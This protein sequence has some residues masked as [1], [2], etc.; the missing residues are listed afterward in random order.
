V[1]VTIILLLAGSWVSTPPGPSVVSAQGGGEDA[2]SLPGGWMAIA[3]GDYVLALA[4]EGEFVWAGT[5]AGGAIRWDPATGAYTQYL[6]PQHGIAGNIVYDIAI[7]AAGNRWFATNRGLSRLAPDGSWSTFTTA[8][9]GG[10]LPSDHVTAVAVGP[11]GEVWV[12]TR[13]LMRLTTSFDGHEYYAGGVARL[14]PNGTWNTWTV[15]QGVSS[16]NIT[17]IAIEPGTGKVWVT[18]EPYRYWIPPTDPTNPQDMGSWGY[19]GGGVSLWTGDRWTIYQRTT[20]Q[21]FPSHDTVRAVAIDGQGRRWFATWG[22][23]LNVLEG[24]S[25]WTKFTASPGGLAGNY[26]TSLA[27][28]S[29][30][31]VWCGVAGSVA[32]QGRGVSVLNHNGTISDPTDDVWTQYTRETT[33]N[34]LAGDEVQAILIGADGAVWFGTGGLKGNGSGLSRLTT[35]GTWSTF[36]TA[37]NGLLSNQITAI[38]FGPDGSVW[39]GTGDL[40]DWGGR[41]RGVNVLRADGSWTSYNAAYRSRG[42][43]VTTVTAAAA[44]GST[45]IPVGFTSRTQA[46]AALP[47]GLVMFGDDPTIYTYITFYSSSRT[48]KIQPGLVQ[49]V[50]AGTPVYAVNLGLAS[51]NV[52]DIAFDASG[53]PWVGSRWETWDS[54]TQVWLDGGVSTFDGA[55]T[56]YTESSGLISN[57]VSAVAIE[58]PNCGGKIWVGTGRLYDYSGFGISRFDPAQ[59]TWVRFTS[60]LSSLNITDAVVDPA[61]CNVWFAT[62]PY[63]SNGNWTGGGVSLFDRASSSWIKLNQTSGLVAYGDDVRSIAV[64]PEGVVWAG[65]YQYTGRQLSLDWP[66]VSAAVNRRL[67]GSWTS[68]T[69]PQQGWVSALA[70]DRQGR[71]WAGTSRGR[72]TPDV[73]DGGIYILE[74]DKWSHLTAANSGLPSNVGIQVIAVDGADNVWIGT[75]DQGIVRYS[76]P[77][78]APSNL[79]CTPL[80]DS[81]IQLQWTDNSADETDFRVERSLNGES[82]WREIATVL[83]NTTVYTDT[84]LAA[85]TSY[86][87][88]VRAHRLQDDSYSAFAGPT[89]CTTLLPPTSTPTATS[90]PTH[91]PTPTLTA[92]V[93]QTPTS[94]PTPTVTRT[95]EPTSTATGTPAVSPTA[96]ATPTQTLTPTRTPSPTITP[97][98]TPDRV[99][100]VY[101]PLVNNERITI[102]STPTPFITRQPTPTSALTGTPPTVVPTETR[103]PTATHT[104]TPTPAPSATATW[105]PTIMPTVTS[106]ATATWSP[107]LMPTATSS[108][109]VTPPATASPTPTA[110]VTPTATETETPTTT[111]SPT[112]TPSSVWTFQSLQDVGSLRGLDF[113]SPGLGWAVGEGGIILRYDGRSWVPEDSPTGNTLNAIDMVSADEGWAV[114]ENR[115]VLHRVNGRWN[116]Y[117]PDLVQEDNYI[118]VDM[119]SATN[120][121][122]VG[123]GGSFLEY[124]NGSWRRSYDTPSGLRP[125]H[126]MSLSPSGLRGWAV[127][128]EGLMVEYKVVGSSRYWSAVGD[129]VKQNLYAVHM[130]ADDLAW[131]AGE[132]PALLYYPSTYCGARIPP[133]WVTYPNPPHM[134]QTIYGIYALSPTAVWM[135]GDAGVIYR[136]DGT[137]WTLE[138]PATLGRPTLRA[139]Y[140]LS[141]AEGWAVGDSGTIGHYAAP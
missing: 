44:A 41:G 123:R 121:W 71:L 95:P 58:P 124:R 93:T 119:I 129:V 65:G 102:K 100:K 6:R 103:E 97:S 76:P 16:N 137:R 37:T 22:G 120:G 35:T 75:V 46:N 30:G 57:N 91:T 8:N 138:V 17:D 25:R 43:Q 24:T 101:L 108:A 10:G 73:A 89:G 15:A 136:Y 32:G 139:V 9:T 99:R 48:L 70:V 42:S 128:D 113:V 45:S 116:L 21:S 105:P 49:A 19:Q 12:G 34:G 118:G 134:N 18:T 88:R 54:Y 7:D 112:P 14:N 109:T 66:Y 3:N 126:A 72:E 61:T 52:S 68:W 80:S 83:A 60:G 50:T 13:Q 111:P 20:A 135:V 69:F 1:P 55:W 140:M 85:N 117:D 67:G 132:Y 39:I 29:A 47:N 133:C 33:T 86:F 62:A 107:T 81:Q 59:G 51:D 64:G 2:G 53:H 36:R 38:N 114:G 110:T 74:G 79:T 78:A 94:T 23:G 104:F 122:M 87:Y 28:D 106:S 63:N 56:T 96:T 5:Y 40:K 115:T 11:N 26:I 90:T 92:T 4:R 125:L 27:V 31:Q 127:G 84:G 82:G 130:P 141:P 77:P 98:A 131:N